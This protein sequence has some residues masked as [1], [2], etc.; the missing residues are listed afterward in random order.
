[1]H[2]ITCLKTNRFKTSLFYYDAQ[3]EPYDDPWCVYLA[4]IT[5][6]DVGKE[7]LIKEKSNY[8]RNT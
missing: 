3:H 7:G 5:K 1:M 2:G 6:Y 4:M 8:V